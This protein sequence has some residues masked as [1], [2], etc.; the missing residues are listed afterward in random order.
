MFKNFSIKKKLGITVLTVSVIA[1]FSGFIILKWQAIQIEKNI[2]NLFV[3]N[4]Q[5]KAKENFEIKNDIG[6]SNAVSISNNERIKT[7]LQNNKRELAVQNLKLIK[8]QMSESTPFK[9]IKI[10][11]HTKDNKSFIRS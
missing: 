9:N 7:A 5:L 10:H 11:I 1:L 2:D 3:K 6:I 4:L 8:K